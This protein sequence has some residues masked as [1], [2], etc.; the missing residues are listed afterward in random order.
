MSLYIYLGLSNFA[1]CIFCTFLEHFTMGCH[2]VMVPYMLLYFYGNFA[3]LLKLI[4]FNTLLEM[5][6]NNF[7]YISG[8]ISTD[9]SIF[10][11]VTMVTV[12]VYKIY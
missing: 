3:L 6:L 4:N 5:L 10:Q 8:E 12:T 2:N 11:R 9:R 1:F 7:T